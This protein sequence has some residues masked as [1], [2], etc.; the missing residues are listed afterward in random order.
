M[1]IL[2]V[3]TVATRANAKL[4]ELERETPSLHKFVEQQ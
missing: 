4:R 3:L 2:K 1:T